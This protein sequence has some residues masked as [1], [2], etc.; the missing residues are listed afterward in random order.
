M[1]TA[2]AEHQLVAHDFEVFFNVSVSSSTSLYALH[3]DIIVIIHYQKRKF[4]LFQ[5]SHRV[6]FQFFR[7]LYN[8]KQ[9]IWL[10]RNGFDALPTTLNYMHCGM[11]RP[12]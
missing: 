10:G 3:S 5:N 7:V 9:A 4:G 12:R 11:S 6:H 8:S 2:A 1:Q